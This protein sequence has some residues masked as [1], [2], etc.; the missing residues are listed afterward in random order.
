MKKYKIEKRDGE[1]RVGVRN[2]QADRKIRRKK[3]YFTIG[4]RWT[5]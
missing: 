4:T 2:K 5:K 3:N 1:E